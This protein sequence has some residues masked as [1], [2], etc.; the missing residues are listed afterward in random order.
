MS[1]SRKVDNITMTGGNSSLAVVTEE[2]I[3]KMLAFLEC[4]VLQSS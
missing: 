2:E 1:S 3:L 4:V